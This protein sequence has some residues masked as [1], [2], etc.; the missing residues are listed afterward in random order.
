[1]EEQYFEI[2]DKYL[3]K[4]LGLCEFTSY[5]DGKSTL[6][7][8]DNDN[9][10]YIDFSYDNNTDIFTHEVSMIIGS[11]DLLVML[12]TQ[13]LEDSYNYMMLHVKENKEA[14]DSYVDDFEQFNGQKA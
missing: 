3:R 10:I 2:S 9:G 13:Q 8:D 11:E 4:L 14:L 5:V 6:V 12:T 1:M 7:L